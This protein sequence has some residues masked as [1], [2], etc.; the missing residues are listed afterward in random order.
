MIRAKNL[1]KNYGNHKVLRGVNIEV[2]KGDIYGFIGHN[3][4]GKST[5]M[6]ILTGLINHQGGECIVNGSVG[7]LPEDPKFYP[8][9]NAWE[10]LEFIGTMGGCPKKDIKQTSGKLL[11]MVKLTSA[12]K[13]AIGGYSRGMKQRFGI[14]VALFHNPEILLLDEP[15]SALDPQGRVDVAD[16]IMRLKEGG[17]TVFFSTHI[18]NDVE[19]ICNKIGIL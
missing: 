4:A 10:Y 6:N 2:N 3:G 16:I 17:K 12:S 19:R 5:T 9:M 18:L 7:Y 13:R 11:D 15:Y 8:Y 1:V 14:A